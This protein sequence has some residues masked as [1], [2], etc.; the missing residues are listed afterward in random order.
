MSISISDFVILADGRK[1]EKY[2]I[3][4]SKGLSISVITYG[5]T[6]LTAS[7]PD[8]NGEFKDVLVG[9]DDLTGCVER[10]DYQGVIVGPYANRIG[11][12]EFNIVYIYILFC[13][14][15]QGKISL[16]K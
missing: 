7:V 16:K 15:V 11:N 8:K 3:T 9:F 2:T 13:A 5:A 10:T 1:I 4:N 14:S 6:L 12:S